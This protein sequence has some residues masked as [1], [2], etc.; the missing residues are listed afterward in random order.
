MARVKKSEEPIKAHSI[1]IISTLGS[2]SKASMEMISLRMVPTTRDLCFISF[3][4]EHARASMSHPASTAPTNSMI[5]PLV[6]AL[7]IVS[8]LELTEV[9]NELATS[10]APMLHASR[11]AKQMPNPKM[12]EY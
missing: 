11:K 2:C 4:P 6:I 5:P 8:D 7:V 9:A 12:Y 3:G 10:L 1:P